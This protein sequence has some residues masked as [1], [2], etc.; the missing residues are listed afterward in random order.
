MPMDCRPVE[1]DRPTAAAV[2]SPKTFVSSLSSLVIYPVCLLVFC[3]VLFGYRL[4]ERDLWSSHEGRAAQDAQTILNERDWGLPRLFDQRPELQKPPLYYWMVA[5]VAR[6]RGGTVDA[7]AVRLPATL[8]AIGGVLGVYVFMVGRRRPLAA[9]FAALML[10]TAVNYTW[11]ARTGRIDMPL[12]LA[13]GGAVCGFFVAQRRRQEQKPAW[14]WLLVFYGMM[15]SAILLKGPI[16]AVLIFAVAGVYWLTEG[17]LSA[18]RKWRV[19]LPLANESGLWWGLPLVLAICVPW[20]AW[21]AIRTQGSLLWTFFWHHNVERALGGSTL[22]AHPW[23]LYGPYLVIYLLPWSLL[24]PVAG[25]FYWRR[26]NLPRDVEACFGLVWLVA[27]VLVLSMA[28][29]KRADYLLPAFPG[30][31]LFLGCAAERW[32]ENTRRRKSLAALFG[33]IL[34]GC[35]AGWWVYVD[36]VL[37]A[38]E[39]A[40]EYKRF[41]AAI[42]RLVP[43]P[44]LVLFFRAEAHALAFHVG[45]PIDTFL[46]WENLDIWAGRSGCHYIVM[47]EDCAA[48]WP[49]HV[50]SGRLEEVSRSTDLPGAGHRQRPLVLMRTRPGVVPHR[51]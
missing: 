11:L 13:V 21:A 16:G 32:Y 10:A 1:M 36:R 27:I 4:T 17:K 50:T 44:D 49:E 6:L 19:W 33:L 15:G 43:A 48:E 41:A 47:P 3:W 28:R 26:R 23:Y 24:L 5:L 18:S 51:P 30:A 46:E 9:L 40:R 12:T 25:W 35:L 37:P 8:A 22:R 2:A 20:Y 45:P 31:A 34:V 42:R 29:F 14:P 7:L 38:D 39:P